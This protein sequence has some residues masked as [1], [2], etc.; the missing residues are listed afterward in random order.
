[1]GGVGG[2]LSLPGF[3]AAFELRLLDRQSALHL[4][5]KLSLSE[6]GRS[7]NVDVEVGCC[8]CTMVTGGSMHS[9]LRC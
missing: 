7:A 3:N 4:I 5:W 1:M 6:I 2:V 9:P 8:I